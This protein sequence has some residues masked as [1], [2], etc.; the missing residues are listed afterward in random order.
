[1]HE[2]LT[3][4]PYIIGFILSLVLTFGAFFIVNQHVTTHHVEFS[5]TFIITTILILAVAQLLVQLFFFLHMG[6]EKKP[7]WNMYIFI[8]FISLI[9]MIV[10]ASLWIMYHLNYNMMPKEMETTILKD[11]MMEMPGY[12]GGEKQKLIQKHR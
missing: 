5:H 7:R 9:L 8:A 2:K 10:I 4:K 6:Q 1:M 12:S 11:E 3:M